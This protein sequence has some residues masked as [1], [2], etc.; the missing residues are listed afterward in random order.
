MSGKLVRNALVMYDHQTD[1]L[2]SHFTGDA[3]SGELEGTKL[4]IVPALHTTWLRWKELHPDSLVLDKRG[5]YRSD[6]YEYYYGDSG[7][8][9]IGE[10]NIDD[11][12][13]L[14]EFV[15]GLVLDGQAKAY[16]FGDLNDTPVVNDTFAG[17]ELVVTFETRAATGGVFSRVLD[18]QTLTFQET[19]EE[20]IGGPTMTDDQTG[21]VWLMLTGEAIEGE[22]EGTALEQIPSNYSF[23]FSW[24][25]YYPNTLLYPEDGPY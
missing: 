2:W 14:K 18:G 4:E 1:S 11:R 17:R 8:G 3:I 9:V 5:F 10:A 22:L 15:V 7:A 6:I 13:Y 21:S 12:L 25:D 20:V 16:P 24:N 23:W 19:G